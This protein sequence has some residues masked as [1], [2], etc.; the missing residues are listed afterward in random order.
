MSARHAHSAHRLQAMADTLSADTATREGTTPGFRGAWNWYP[1][2]PLARSPIASWPPS[3]LIFLKSLV[4]GWLPISDKLIVVGLSVLTWFLFSPALERCREFEVDWIAQIYFR[5]LGL[6]ALVAGGLHL[7]LYTFGCQGDHLRYD[8]RPFHKDNKRYTLSNQVFD[9]V[10]WSLASGVTCWTAYEVVGMWAYANGLMPYLSWGD[11]PAWF[12]AMFVLIQLFGVFHFYW[13]HRWL[14]WKPL[15]RAVHS[16]HHRNV[17]VG[18]WS[19]LSMHPVEHILY[20]SSALVHFVVG[21]HP[22]HFI[23]HLQ[24]KVLLA[25]SSHAGFDTVTVGPKGDRGVRVGDFFHQLHHR[26]IECN[27]GEP[28]IPCDQWFGSFHDGTPE[29]TRR[30]HE[31]M[32]RRRMGR[33]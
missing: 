21:S 8:S 7:Y 24:Q 4:R 15:F 14:H 6:L 31:R 33:R 20:L 3:P 32:R 1:R 27:Y 5:N 23:F 2:I 29:A 28:E 13:I 26:H 25:A 12:V 22:I 17:N 10:F 16:L 30:T 19:G 9:N 11:N 18:P